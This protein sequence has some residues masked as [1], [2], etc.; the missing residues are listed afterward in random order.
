M[1]AILMGIMLMTIVACSVAPDKAA[2][3]DERGDFGFETVPQVTGSATTFKLTCAMTNTKARP[4]LSF[5]IR[6]AVGMSNAGITYIPSKY[7][8]SPELRIERAIAGCEAQ[9]VNFTVV[10]DREINIECGG[11]GDLGYLTAERKGN[12][13]N[14]I[15]HMNF[16]TNGVEGYDYRL[17]P[18][19]CR[20]E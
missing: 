12:A 16:P 19:S 4:Y 20:K 3:K 6:K 18:V 7:L 8:S 5:I 15:G 1:K 11:Y 13:K 9:N 14:F 17:I 2:S 10:T